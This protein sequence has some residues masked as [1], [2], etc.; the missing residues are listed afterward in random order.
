MSLDPVL[1]EILYNKVTAVADEMGITLQRT[2]RTLYVKE[3]AD[4]GTALVTL[5]GKFFGFP[6]QIGVSGFVDLDCGPTIRAVPDLEPGDVIITNH[7][8]L[9]EGLATHTPDIHVVKPYFHAGK[10]VAYGWCFLHS[11][12]VGGRVPSSVLPTNTE[13]FQEG[14]LIPPMK[15]QRRGTLNP[16]F[17]ALFRA[18]VRT[19]DENVGDVK[20]MLA[21]LA[22]GEQRVADMIAQHGLETFQAA[23][24]ELLAYAERKARAV[25]RTVKDGTYEFADFI[26]DD[27]LSPIPVRV[28]L[29]M[30]AKDGFLTLDF[31]GSDVQTQAAFNVCTMGKR[32]PWLTLRILAFIFTR[33]R[34][35]PVNAGVFRN[36]QVTV[37]KGSV[38]HPEFPAPVGVRAATGVRAYD[39]VNGALIQAVPGVMPAAP[40]G[41]T[42]PVVVTEPNEETGTRRITVIQYLVGGMGARLGADGIDGRDSS[43]TNMMN[44][45]IETIEREASV[46]VLYYGIHPDSGGAGQWR[47][48]AGQMVTFEILREGCAVLG[49]GME[50]FR[51]QPWGVAGGGPGQRS[52]TVINPGTKRERELGKI[53]MVPVEKGDVVSVMMAGAG[54]YGDPFK[55]DPAAVLQDVRRGFVS[56]AGA[57]RD[58]GVALKGDAVDAAATKRLRAKAGRSKGKAPTFLFGPER[59]AWD[60]VFDG[61]RL[62][63]LTAALMKLP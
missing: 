45:P 18:N 52:R 33:D 35:V 30:T 32:N 9:S 37:P 48:G 57:R 53:D 23:Q 55:R 5:D 42:V 19:P 29:A 27:M 11:S 40:T 56:P 28:R 44:N 62:D 24:E 51:F 1:L 34:S 38:L 31:T 41:A 8:Y 14:L 13:L 26:D 58:Y 12:D 60:A 22:V 25:L 49:R 20:A 17:L 43:F 59:D 21:A 15:L 63:K 47:G 7:P 3:T 6:R 4:F 54:G 16:D 39:V 36:V 46:K 50:R 61:K 2:G 10:I